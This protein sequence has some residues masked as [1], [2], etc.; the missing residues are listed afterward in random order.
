MVTNCVTWAHHRQPVTDSNRADDALHQSQALLRIAGRLGRIGAWTVDLPDFKI[1]WSDEVAALHGAPAGSA[2]E[3]IEAALAFYTP[4]CRETVRASFVQCARDGTPFDIEVEIIRDAGRLVFARALGEADRGADGRVRRIQGALQDVSDRKRAE[5][6]SRQLAAQ[7]SITLESITDAF[8]TLD[9]EWRFTYF[10]HEAERL[11]QR[12]R[13]EVLGKVVWEEFPQAV[14]TPFHREFQR[15]L[16]DNVTV[17]IEEHY[18][19]FDRWFEVRAYPSAQGLAVYFRDVS[20]ERR[21]S[22]VLRVSEERF[23]LLSQATNDAIWDWD[24]RSGEMWWSEGFETM[25][26]VT[27]EELET[28]PYSWRERVHPDDVNRVVLGFERAL[29]EDAVAWSDE[30]RFR[31]ED[32]TYAFVRDRGQIIRDATGLAIRMIGGMTDL[33]ERKRME[34]QFLRAQRVESIGTLAGGIA[35]DLNNVLAPTL[36]AID[37]LR[38]DEKDTRKL[39]LL[40]TVEASTR[41][42][43]DMVRQVLSFAR[44][45]EGQRVEIH[46]KSLLQDVERIT[47]ETFLK[48]IQISAQS[49][50]G[51]W[52]VL[53]DPTQLHQ[54]LLNLCLNARDA[55]PHGGRITLSAENMTLDA[56][57]VAA[58]P[59]A[60]E[61]PHVC[62]AVEDSGTGMKPE[63]LDRIF[64]PFFTTKELGKGTGLGLSTSLAIVK[65]HGGFLRVYSEPGRGTTFKVFLPA[66]ARSASEAERIAA[67]ELPRGNHELVLVVDDEEAVRDVTRETLEEFGYQVIAAGG[68]PEALALYARRHAEIA[69]VLTDMMMPGMDGPTMIQAMVKMNPAARIVAAS[70]LSLSEK[71]ARATEAGVKA[72]LPKPYAAETLLKTLRTVLTA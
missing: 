30:Y 53:G 44:G 19:P 51:L 18:A 45:V 10:N 21:A 31:R 8:Y 52:A 49:P 22:E 60:R 15:A 12:T 3:T 35:H 33:S 57:W 26:G 7:Y 37:L 63:I 5:A 61:G 28:N 66:Q 43:A 27:R 67:R 55:M 65:S 32:G 6:Q 9:R 40:T 36:M 11:M 29:A 46:L 14:G 39:R 16:R 24:V 2:P 20:I 72:F 54:V 17:F 69:V 23:R 59:D 71:V 47:N 13:Q 42:G 25:F 58:N 50:A 1:T 38:R 34:E 64:D 48:S 41:R 70:G 4:A 68:G 56:A 62:L